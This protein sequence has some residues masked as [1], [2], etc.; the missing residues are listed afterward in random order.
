MADKKTKVK[1]DSVNDEQEMVATTQDFAPDAPPSGWR[2]LSSEDGYAPLTAEA[3]RLRAFEQRESELHKHHKRETVKLSSNPL[4]FPEHLIPEGQE[5]YWVRISVFNEPDYSR[6]DEIQYDQ[7]KAVP[8]SR[9]P[10]WAL[11]DLLGRTSAT[12]NFIVRGGLLLCERSKAYGD[13]VRASLRAY[14]E[15]LTKNL[16]GIGNSKG[17]HQY[18][19]ETTRGNQTPW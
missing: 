14:N 17:I 5:Y 12:S 9:H 18:A 15:G 13:K 3:Q 2:T 19:G 1:A 6:T 7:W 16:Q 10:E 11:P 4:D 8:A